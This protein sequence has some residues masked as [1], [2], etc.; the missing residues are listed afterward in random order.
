MQLACQFGKQPP[1]L[2]TPSVKK[3]RLEA[4]GK[5]WKRGGNFGAHLW[6]IEGD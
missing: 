2:V 1:R 4:S 5:L 6:Q 3:E